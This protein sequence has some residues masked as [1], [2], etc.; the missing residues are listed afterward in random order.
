MTSRSPVQVRARLHAVRG[1]TW[2]PRRHWRRSSSTRCA[3][4][5]S[6]IAAL[7][8]TCDCRWFCRGCIRAGAP[9]AV[10]SRRSSRA[11]DNNAGLRGQADWRRRRWLR[12]C[13]AGRAQG[14]GGSEASTGALSTMPFFPAVLFR[15]HAPSQEQQLAREFPQFRCFQLRAG[16]EG[17]LWHPQP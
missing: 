9:H 6:Y 13:G 5:P 7:T 10:V 12:V 1:S 17:V 2:R 4:S 14:S 11:F 8:H 15:Y 16:G 3:D